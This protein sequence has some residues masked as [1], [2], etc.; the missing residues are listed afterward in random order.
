MTEI[1][2][3]HQAPQKENTKNS[4]YEPTTEEEKAIKLVD[5][6]FSRAKAARKKYDEKWV[7]NY[8]M[9]RGKQWKE[10]RPTYRHSEVINLIFRDIQSVVPIL[11]DNMPKPQFL[12][13]EPNDFEISEIL[14]DVLD[15]D[16]TYNNWS[17]KFTE[18][19]YD[20]HFYGTGFGCMKYDPKS[21]DGLGGIKFASADPFYQFPDP[22]SRNVNERS[23]FYIEAE[24]VDINVLKSEYPQHAQHI[25]SDVT[26]LSKRDKE[27]SEHMR[28]RSP[29]DNRQV[30]EGTGGS[31]L[32][33]TNE[34]LKETCYIKD[35]EVVEEEM[36]EI[37]E[38]GQEKSVYVTKLKYPKGRKIVIGSGV[39]LEDQP[40]DDFYETKFPY[41]RL[42]N[43][44]LPREFWGMSEIEQLE[45]PQKIFNKLVSF[46]LDVLT[47]MGNPIWVVDTSSG[48]DTD[49]LINRPGLVI[50]KEPGSEV[51]REE[52]VHLQ[53]YVLQMIDRMK[54]WFDD[55][56]GSTDASRGVRPEGVTAASA[57]EALQ[58]QAQTRL[59]QK[60]RNIE[61]FMQEFGQTYLDF[62]FEYYDSPRVF[63]ITDNK[64]SVR[65]FKFHVQNREVKN[66]D[67]TPTGE[68]KKYGIVRDYKKSSVE[69]KFFEG[70]AREFELRKR[71]DVKIS[72]G[73]NLPFEKSRIESQSYQL[74]DRG[75]IDAKEVLT[76]I[77]Y[78]NIESVLQRMA[79]KAAQTAAQ[80]PPQG[81]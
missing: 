57:I 26:D 59:R 46:S 66:E 69:N 1:L 73:S 18:I 28:Y 51:R 25:K 55:I 4:N 9:F 35:M 36:K 72:L 62:V 58:D 53:P 41:M 52:G 42:C 65:Y 27:I 43:Y 61:A 8:R 11:T 50:E 78:P 15:S 12:P 3:E 71:F 56:S 76:N 40:M 7:D 80:Q 17:Y 33:N 13:M 30:L 23:S 37:G 5:T 21:F 63:K 38:D 44:I 68:T 49:N 6:L 14:N 47:L 79:E 74:F 45:S 10:Q 39:L 64:N 24:P 70:D 34:A 75:I 2:A 77:K 31:D 67:G 48:I 22:Q 19:I 54:L 29:S 32:D 60:S 81:Q 16:W 20:S